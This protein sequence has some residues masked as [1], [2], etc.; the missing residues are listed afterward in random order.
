VSLGT[1]WLFSGRFT[2]GAWLTGA[3]GLLLGL[4]R[5]HILAI[6]VGSI[7]LAVVFI[8]AGRLGVGRAARVFL[9]VIAIVA[10]VYVVPIAAA[11][12]GIDDGLESFLADQQQNTARG[13]SAVIGEPATSPLA[14]PEAT[15]RV[16]FRPLPYEASSPGMLLSALE[17]MVLLGLVIWRIPTM[18]ANWQIVRKTPFMMLSLAFTAAFVI[19][20]SSIFNLGILARQRSQVIPFLLVVI[21]GLGWR[22]WSP[23]DRARVGTPREEITT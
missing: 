22:R 19:A 23:T 8:R 10:M 11:R 7:V 15:L 16:L 14:L 9:M 12:I 18:W 17:G 20:F 6:A 13:G 21:V 1:M 3:G 4:I 5:P 2:S